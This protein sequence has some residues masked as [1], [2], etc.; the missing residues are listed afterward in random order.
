M[1]DDVLDARYLMTLFLLIILGKQL[2]PPRGF[3]TVFYS[4]RR[5]V[6]AC[7]C[8][9][10]LLEKKTVETVHVEFHGSLFW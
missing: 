4:G 1:F 8:S 5:I 7:I 3:P 6:Q 10:F 9:A 2:S